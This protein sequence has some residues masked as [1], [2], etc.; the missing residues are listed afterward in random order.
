MN[1]EIHIAITRNVK[2][3]REHEFEQLLLQFAQRSL[4]EPGARGVHVLYPPPESRSREYGILRT[5]AGPSD[6][7]AFYHSELYRNWIAK[8]GTLVVGEPAYRQLNG[9]EAW[10]R[11]PRVSPPEWKMALL[12]WVAVWPVSM[13]VPAALNPLIGSRIPNVIFAGAVAAGIVLVL[14]W[15]AMPALVWLAGPWLSPTLKP[16]PPKP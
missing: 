7:D 3:G 11:D 1:Q 8:I 5:F 6:R 14:T 16:S 2:P 10:F 9:L 13:A 15:V 12:T 4:L